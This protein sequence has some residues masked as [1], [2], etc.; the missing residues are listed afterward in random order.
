MLVGGALR[1][2]VLWAAPF[3]VSACG[4]AAPAGHDVVSAVEVRGA[5]AAEVEDESNLLDGLATREDEIYDVDVLGKDL[6]RIRRFYRAR[7]YYAAVVRAARVVRV[8]PQKVRVEIEVALGAPVL[9]TR[10]DLAGT[11]A[12]PSALA[13]EAR[14]AVELKVG[15]RLDEALFHEAARDIEHAL[16]DEG[17]AFAKVSERAEVSV[18]NRTAR[19]EYRLTPG[20]PAVIGDIAVQGL[21]ELDETAVRARLGLE[22]GARFSRRDLE[23]ARRRLFG[24]GIFS[25]VD[26]KP[27]LKTPEN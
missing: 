15:D 13:G 4:A 25:A 27:N 12:L 21:G 11:E 1:L 14:R 7:G 26:I 16:M 23:A 19:V 9:V 24:L 5:A 8:A 22:K 2:A 6:E 20:R 10:I 3:G 17:Y 18:V